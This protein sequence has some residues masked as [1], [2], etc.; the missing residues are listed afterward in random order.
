MTTDR[1]KSYIKKWFEANRP[2]YKVGGILTDEFIDEVFEII[3]P[4][5][6]GVEE[7]EMRFAISSDLEF[8]FNKEFFFVAYKMVIDLFERQYPDEYRKIEERD[9]NLIKQIASNVV[10]S[11]EKQGFI[12]ASS[13]W[14]DETRSAELDEETLCE[15]FIDELPKHFPKD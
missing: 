8:S 14:N 15:L 3:Y 13:V 11:G 1:I 5:I 9:K 6:D 7:E 10:F 12:I 4:D 2:D